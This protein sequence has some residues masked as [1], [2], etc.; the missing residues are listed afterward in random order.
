MI[1]KKIDCIIKEKK[2]YQRSYRVVYYLLYYVGWIIYLYIMHLYIRAGLRK[3]KIY[4]EI[5]HYNL[6]NNVLWWISCN[7]VISGQ[8]LIKICNT[9]HL[10]HKLWI[11]K[12]Y[13]NIKY[14][15]TFFFG[16]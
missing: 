1:R 13:G 15:F 9:V 14:N 6:I 5:R 3:L 4:G 11:R 2:F 7:I 10:R 8:K 12:Q 16:F